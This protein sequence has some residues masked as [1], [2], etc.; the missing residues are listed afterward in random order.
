MSKSLNASPISSF[1]GA[2]IAASLIS[3]MKEKVDAMKADAGKAASAPTSA[4]AY[5]TPPVE[6]STP[7]SV[8]LRESAY[9]IDDDAKRDV[10]GLI[11]R[12]FENFQSVFFRDYPEGGMCW[13]DYDRPH[14]DAPHTYACVSEMSKGL[15]KEFSEAVSVVSGGDVFLL[16]VG[17]AI[18]LRRAMGLPVPKEYYTAGSMLKK[19]EKLA[20]EE[21]A[22]AAPEPVTAPAPRIVQVGDTIRITKDRADNADVKAGDV[23]TVARV[24]NDEGGVE[25]QAFTPI[26][27]WCFSA[28][29]YTIVE[30]TPEPAT[31]PATPKAGDTVRVTGRTMHPTTSSF[32]DVGKTYTVA[33]IRGERLR[34]NIEACPWVN[35]VDVEVVEG[36]TKAAVEAPALNLPKEYAGLEYGDTVVSPDGERY[37]VT[38]LEKCPNCGTTGFRL[39]DGRFLHL[40]GGLKIE[41]AAKVDATDA[42]TITRYVTRKAEVGEKIRILFDRANGADVRKGDVLTVEGPHPAGNG[43]VNARDSKGVMWAISKLNYEV[44][45]V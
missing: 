14:H 43:S 26:G 21:R 31:E 7:D 44:E 9:T 28:D 35:V 22:S 29:S 17:R 34:L 38:V 6:P 19:A 20:G 30:D 33:E 5:P 42:D 3:A 45:N 39:E 41:K 36:D 15:T 11:D 18:S 2:M 16:N 27:G 37:T 25:T 8:A 40:Y 10:A 12:A 1:L 4:S 24:I 32:A 13:N 23:F